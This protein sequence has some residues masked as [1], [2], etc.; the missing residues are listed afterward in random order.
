MTVQTAVD[1][2]YEP[3]YEEEEPTLLIVPPTEMERELNQKWEDYQSNK[4]K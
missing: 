1:L 2:M 3:S 4:T